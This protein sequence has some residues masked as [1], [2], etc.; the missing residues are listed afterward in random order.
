MSPKLDMQIQMPRRAEDRVDSSE[1]PPAAAWYL[2]SAKR[3][4]DPLLVGSDHGLDSRVL[5]HHHS[6]DCLPCRFGGVPASSSKV[7]AAP[8]VMVVGRRRLLFGGVV[9]CNWD[10]A[11]WRSWDTVGSGHSPE[12]P[13]IAP[14]AASQ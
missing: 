9:D 2:P 6:L 5:A 7:G 13:R 3:P 12:G 8:A 14:T 10:G 4:L 11:V 1:R